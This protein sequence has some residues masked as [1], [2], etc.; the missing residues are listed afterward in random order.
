[1][2]ISERQLEDYIC[3]HLDLLIMYWDDIA[4]L[5]GTEPHIRVPHGIVYDSLDA[6]ITGRINAMMHY[7]GER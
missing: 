5:S 6:E 4:E 7:K 2:G 1:M 3:E